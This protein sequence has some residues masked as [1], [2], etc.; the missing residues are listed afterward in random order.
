VVYRSF[1]RMTAYLKVPVRN[2]GDRSISRAQRGIFPAG[3]GEECR[4]LNDTA[5]DAD[6]ILRPNVEPLR[7]LWS[8][9]LER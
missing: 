3:G 8:A 4:V 7:G 5:G 9:E 1:C 2:N 6:K